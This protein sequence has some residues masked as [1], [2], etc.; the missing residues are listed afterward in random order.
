MAPHISL[1]FQGL[2]NNA[3]APDDWAAPKN[4]VIQTKKNYVK[5]LEKDALLRVLDNVESAPQDIIS[6]KFPHCSYSSSE[7]NNNRPH[8]GQARL[9]FSLN[10]GKQHT[11][12]SQGLT[13]V[14]FFKIYSNATNGNMILKLI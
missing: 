11:H 10:F 6:S 9:R 2:T 8:L 14:F 3:P 1:M 7:S 4:C 12:S 5:S 13:Y